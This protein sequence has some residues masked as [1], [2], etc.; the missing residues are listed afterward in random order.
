MTKK[1]T[2][3]KER[4]PVINSNDWDE[5]PLQ[6]WIENDGAIHYKYLFQKRWKGSFVLLLDCVQNNLDDGMIDWVGVQK[7]YQENEDAK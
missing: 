7:C 5:A 1:K 4:S 6:I 3:K 2:E